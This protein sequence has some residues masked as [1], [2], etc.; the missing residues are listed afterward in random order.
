MNSP[1]LTFNNRVEPVA[2][3]VARRIL[4]G[5]YAAGQRLPTESELQHS[6]GVSRSVVREA[7]K[8]LAS[9]GLVRIEQGRGTFVTNTPQAPL[10]AQLELTLRRGTPHHGAGTETPDEWTH[11][12]DVRRVL[13]VAVAER[14]AEHA[15][16]ADFAAMEAAMAEMREKPDEPTGYVDADLAF[17]RVLADATGN[18]LWPALLNSLNDLLRRYRE[19]GFRGVDSALLAAQQHQVVLEAVRA[20]DGKAAAAAMQV[21][22]ERSEQDLKPR[23]R[24]HKTEASGAKGEGK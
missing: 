20:G 22:L 3:D 12:L 9:Q 4:D 19:A 2:Q 18:P 14:A 8:M 5:E 11:L 23:G 13:E 7:M 17:H 16:D 10:S 1:T 6:W 15:T 21:H 24:N